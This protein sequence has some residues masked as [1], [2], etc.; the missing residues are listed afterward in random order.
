MPIQTSWYDDQ[1]R[2]VW[3]QFS[4]N[5]TWAELGQALIAMQELP[6]PAEG[7]FIVL[8]DMSNTSIMPQGNV[9]MQGKQ[10]F[11]QSPQNIRLI[12]FVLESR[13]IKAFVGVVFDLMPSWKNRLQFTR[14]REEALKI[15]NETVAKSK[16]V[17]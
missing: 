9:L 14:T 2:V 17:A 1:H 11:K 4:G 3:Q 5:W 13:L 10:I 6:D 16:T 8:N 15:I 7:D 12:V